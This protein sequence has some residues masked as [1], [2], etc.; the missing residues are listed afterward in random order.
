MTVNQ[1]HRSKRYTFNSA[2]RAAKPI[3][4]RLRKQNFFKEEGWNC[5]ECCHVLRQL[6]DSHV[7][8][9]KYSKSVKSY[10]YSWRSAVDIVFE[11][12]VKA[13]AEKILING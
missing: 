5:E 4:K 10:T 11:E 1:F 3:I 9:Y 12:R 6:S 8:V 7:A 13:E 2:E